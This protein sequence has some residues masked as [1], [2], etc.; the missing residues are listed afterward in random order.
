[1]DAKIVELTN[2]VNAKI[3]EHTSTINSKV[4]E[5]NSKLQTV[6]NKI[7][8]VNS[9]VSNANATVTVLKQDVA[10]A[11]AGIDTKIATSLE[12][13]ADKN[14]NH[15]TLYLGKTA[16]AES[17]KSADAVAWGNVTGK[18]STFAPATHN[19][20]SSYL[21]LSGGTVTGTVNATNLQVGG[22]NVYTTSRKPTPAD[23]SLS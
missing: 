5:V 2:A 3:T 20:D 8:E 19:H 13:K 15:D 4:A 9:T 6:D 10:T 11:I 7:S 23:R 22:A 21:K 17:A 16:K 1:M 14:H 18:P 12:G